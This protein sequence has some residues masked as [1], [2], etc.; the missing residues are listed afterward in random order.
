MDLIPIIKSGDG[1][2]EY[3]YDLS[4]KIQLPGAHGDEIVRDLYTDVHV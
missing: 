2:L 3:A 1:P 4:K